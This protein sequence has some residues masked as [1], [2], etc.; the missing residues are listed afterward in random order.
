MNDVVSQPKVIKMT[1][2]YRI[3]G[4]EEGTVSTPLEVM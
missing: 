2:I 4:G 1:S 3:E